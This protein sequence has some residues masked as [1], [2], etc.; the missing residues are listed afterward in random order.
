MSDDLDVRYGGAIVVDTAVLRDVGARLVTITASVEAAWGGASRAYALLMGSAACR[1]W[2]GFDALGRAGARWNA[3]HAEFEKIASRTLLM[4]DVYE[5][6]ELRAQAAVVAAG[7]QAL[8]DELRARADRIAASDGRIGE[9]ADRLV[10]EWSAHRFDGLGTQGLA[11]SPLGGA[12]GTLLLGIGIV[13]GAARTGVVPAGSVLRGKADAVTVTPVKASSPSGPPT[14]LPDA[15]RRFPT[16]AGAQVKVERY[17]MPD[18]S[19]HFVVYAKGT[20]SVSYGGKE[21]WDMKSNKELY[22]GETSA[23]YQ[24]TMDA[25]KEAGAEEGDRVDVFA[26][27]QAGMIAAHLAMGSEYDV[28]VEVTAGSPVEPTLGEDQ[29]LVQLRHTDDLVSSLAGG[30]SPGGTGA[31]DSFT[32]ERV[33]DPDPGLQDFMLRTHMLESYVE[34]AEMLEASGDPRLDALDDY[35]NELGRAEQIESTEYHAE[36][37]DD[38]GDECE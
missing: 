3:L 11:G 12:F 33:G 24:A 35:W 14:S 38:G 19:N 9:L 29:L 8:A 36:R 17:A 2:S 23:S 37:V 25:L 28:Q 10:A 34:T 22:S 20:Q 5:V 18:G 31:P 21:P 16:T 7:D 6:V 30:G 1:A 26:H 4:A 15:L 27:S 13:A 32:A